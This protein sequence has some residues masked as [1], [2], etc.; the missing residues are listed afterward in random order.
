MTNDNLVM[1]AAKL[2]EAAARKSGDTFD[3][4]CEAAMREARD[5]WLTT[6]EDVRF[7]GAVGGLLLA[8][9]D[10]PEITKRLED[11]MASLKAMSAMLSGVPVDLERAVGRAEESEPLG[12]LKRWRELAAS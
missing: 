11:E 6:D 10:D 4:R 7:R 12:L 3:E 5:F 2:A 1:I 9:R 8:Y